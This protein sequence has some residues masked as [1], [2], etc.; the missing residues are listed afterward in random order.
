MLLGLAWG[1]QQGLVD[2]EVKS[3]MLPQVPR[4]FQRQFSYG[5]TR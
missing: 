3:R 5:H 1:P 4:K 2:H